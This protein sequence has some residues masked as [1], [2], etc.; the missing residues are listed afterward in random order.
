M[1][2][3]IIA[4]VSSTALAARM[5]AGEKKSASIGSSF[6]ASKYNLKILQKSIE[7]DKNNMTRFFLIGHNT[8][9]PTARDKTSIIFFLQ[10]KPG[11]LYKC[12]SVLAEKKINM[13][14]IESRPAKTKKWEYL[15][16]VDMEGHI[17]NKTV[18]DALKEME[19]HCVFL[20][21]LGSYPQGDMPEVGR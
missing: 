10:H 1:P 16:F 19:K 8:S 9:L 18:G 11:A 6:A 7:D 12:L 14:R 13:T 15:F 2:G 20:K 17:K 21:I 4:E 5:A 3:V